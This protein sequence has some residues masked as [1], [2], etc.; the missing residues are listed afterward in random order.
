[1]TTI[2]L[3]MSSVA[4]DDSPRFIIKCGSVYYLTKAVW[5]YDDSHATT[6]E[7]HDGCA[8]MATNFNSV[9]DDPTITV[10]AWPGASGGDPNQTFHP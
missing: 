2:Y 10:R 6:Q 3:S 5:E 9:P 8:Q 1:M 7:Q 4:A